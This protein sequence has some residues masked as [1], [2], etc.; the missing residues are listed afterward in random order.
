MRFLF[1]TVWNTLVVVNPYFLLKIW[2]QLVF[3]VKAVTYIPNFVNKENGT[4][5][6]QK[7]KSTSDKI[8]EEINLL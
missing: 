2:L 7:S 1:M 5:F 8:V 3:L 6:L 4:H